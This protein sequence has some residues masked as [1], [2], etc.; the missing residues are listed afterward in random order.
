MSSKSLPHHGAGVSESESAGKF[1]YLA[2]PWSPIGGGMYKVVDYLVQAQLQDGRLRP[3]DTRGVGSAAASTVVLLSAIG[4]IL[5]GRLQGRLAG[6]H[7]HMA[8][9]LSTWRKGLL[10]LFCRAVGVPVILHLHA[11]QMH[12]EFGKLSRGAKWLVRT[13][14]AQADRCV[15]L[16]PRYQRFVTETLRVPAA[17]VDVVNNGVPRPTASR[18][19]DVPGRQP[20]ILFL[21]NLLERKGVSDL[22]HALSSPSMQTLDWQ[23]VFAGGG[24]VEGY[25]RKAAE[26]GLADRANFVGWAD[27]AKA[28]ALMS[29]ADVLVLPSYDEGLPLVILEALAN[30]VAVVCTPVGEI[31]DVFRHGETAHFVEPGDVPGI[32]SALA[33]LISDGEYRRGLEARGHALYERQFSLDVF[34][35]RVGQLHRESFGLSARES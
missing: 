4:R 28:S 19:S 24:D 16:G 31:P 14:F 21:G 6:V 11:A 26:L 18:R 1:I 9:R 29:T 17:R 30:G 3:L 8:E 22:L 12:L 20:V 10:V 35:D 25:R 34:A 7:V 13:I 33:H 27:Q 2:C 15:V 5:A 23:A 32:A